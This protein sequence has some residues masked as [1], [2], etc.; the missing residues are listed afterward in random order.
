M[1][2]KQNWF[3]LIICIVGFVAA[4]SL[5]G[6]A[7]SGNIN[8]WYAGLNKPP[9]NPPD[10]IFAPVWTLL[11]G[12]MGVSLYRVLRTEASGLKRKALQVFT[13]Q[14]LLNLAWSF[15]FFHFRNP[16][17]ALI[18]IILLLVCII[19]MIR[20]FSRIDRPAAWLQAPYLAWVSFATVL[21]VSIWILN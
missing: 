3:L 10:A 8:T 9:Y 6:I 11:Y 20:I 18:E 21:N 1:H 14:F 13:L 12:L 4:G 15:I 19:W 2:A 5:A 17:L 16:G 7:N